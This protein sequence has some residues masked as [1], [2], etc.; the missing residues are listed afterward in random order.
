MVGVVFV[1]GWVCGG[2]G[3]CGVGGGEVEEARGGA[4]VRVGLNWGGEVLYPFASCG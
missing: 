1:G 4:M 3:G 2:E